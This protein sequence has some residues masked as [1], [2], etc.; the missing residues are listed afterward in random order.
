[1]FHWLPRSVFWRGLLA[2]AIGLIAVLWPRVTILSVVVIFAVAVFVDAAHQ[3]TRAF[4]SD[5][6]GPVAGHARHGE[7]RRRRLLQPGAG[8]DERR[9]PDGGRAPRA[10]A[11]RPGRP[12]RRE[13]AAA[14][15]GHAE[16]VGLPGF[17]LRAHGTTLY[18]SIYRF[19]SQMLVNTHLW[20]VNAY[21]APVL[22]V[23]QLQGG[24]LFAGYLES[25]E[26]VWAVGRPVEPQRASA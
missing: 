8:R 23:R 11:A 25:F 20:G 22:H 3:A 7:L 16:L 6:A 15:P 13:A 18:K 17:A 19:D 4:S 26:A 1:M 2:V 12:R 21:G 10:G 5:S 14:A 24:G 9:R